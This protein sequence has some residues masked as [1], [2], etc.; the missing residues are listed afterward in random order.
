[1]GIKEGESIECIYCIIIIIGV[2][3]THSFGKSSRHK[4]NER[5]EDIFI[6]HIHLVFFFGRALGL[7]GL[8]LFPK[9]IEF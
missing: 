1:M 8:K 7:L 4:N 2:T 9:V 6:V 3:Q 5:N